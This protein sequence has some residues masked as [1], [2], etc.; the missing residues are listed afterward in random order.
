MQVTRIG[1]AGTGTGDYSAM[2]QFLTAVLGL[3]L[4]REAPDF[5]VL[6]CL[7]R[8]LRGVRPQRPRPV[9]L[10]DRPGGAR[11]AFPSPAVHGLYQRPSCPSICVGGWEL[12]RRYGGLTVAWW[13]S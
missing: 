8:H 2:V 3:T 13:I 4:A 7:R 6:D 12:D 1:W 10:H 11:T 9:V 5:A